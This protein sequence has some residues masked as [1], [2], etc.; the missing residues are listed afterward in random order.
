MSDIFLS[1]SS[2][3]KA[4]AEIIAE[5][6]EARGCSVWWDMVIPPGQTFDEVI[7]QELDAAKC[8]IVLW[9]HK[10]VKSKWVKT[11]ASEGDRRGILVPVLIEED[12]KIPLAFRLIEAANLIDWEGTLPHPEFDLLVDSISKILGRP[13]CEENTSDKYE[14]A[15]SIVSRKLILMRVVFSPAEMGS[16]S[17]GLIK[18][19]IAK[20]G[21][22]KWLEN[23]RKIENFW[24]ELEKEIDALNLDY[25]KTR[26]YQ[27]GLPAGGELGMK[28]VRETAEKGSRNFQ[29]VRKLIERGASVEATESPDL[30][31]KEYEHIKAVVIATTPEEKA[32][33]TRRYEKIKDEVLQERDTYIAKTID[34][35]LRDNETGLLFIGAAHNVVPKLPA[36]IEIIQLF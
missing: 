17:D 27:D 16:L 5:A 21:K 3:D 13:L 6:L 14:R 28:I 10:S 4:R 20:M 35:T 29:I 34:S 1:Y 26:L 22:E 36:D 12:V 11:E 19:G 9:S 32:E 8:V 31:R 33:A 24:H 15:G 23:Q 25:K 18:E 30:L 2:K 7:E